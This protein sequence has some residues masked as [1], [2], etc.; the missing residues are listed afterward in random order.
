MITKNETDNLTNDKLLPVQ[1]CPLLNSIASAPVTAPGQMSGVEALF[2]QVTVACSL[3][4]FSPF[5]AG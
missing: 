3:R 5:P 2:Q 4:V 1:A